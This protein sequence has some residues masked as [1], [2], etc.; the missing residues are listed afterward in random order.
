MYLHKLII[1]GLL[2][3][4]IGNAYAWDEETGQVGNETLNTGFNPFINMSSSEIP[5]EYTYEREIMNMPFTQGSYTSNNAI[6]ICTNYKIYK[7]IWDGSSYV[8]INNCNISID[9]C[10]NLD[11]DANKKQYV[12]PENY[13]DVM[14]NGFLVKKYFQEL[15]NSNDIYCSTYNNSDEI[16]HPDVLYTEINIDASDGNEYIGY[17][18]TSLD[19]NAEMELSSYGNIDYG[20]SNIGKGSDAGTGSI[21]QGLNLYGSG[22]GDTTGMSE[23]FNLIFWALIPFIFILCVFKMIGKII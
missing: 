21:Y 13:K 7:Q 16:K 18:Y 22:G 10:I 15:I 19:D 12:L 14:T 2:L 3:I 8:Q 11:Y 9:T 4:S 5:F 20:F 6:A 1:I 17:I 23:L